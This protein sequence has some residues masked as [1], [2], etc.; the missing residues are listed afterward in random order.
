M[1][2]HITSRFNKT[3]PVKAKA[4]KPGK[5][6]T[7]KR[8]LLYFPTH[9]AV[10][11]KRVNISYGSTEGVISFE[12]DKNGQLCI[13]KSG[14]R[15]HIGLH[16]VALKTMGKKMPHGAYVPMKWNNVPSSYKAD[17]LVSKSHHF[18]SFDPNLTA[19]LSTPVSGAAVSTRKCKRLKSSKRKKLT[20]KGI[21]I[22]RSLKAYHRGRKDALNSK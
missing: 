9:S 15:A 2:T 3:C 8:T 12:P 7:L 17:P 10:P 19:Q 5:Y 4:K 1:I 13:T 22:S 20:K 21:N 18:F 11:S 14:S 16:S 6:F